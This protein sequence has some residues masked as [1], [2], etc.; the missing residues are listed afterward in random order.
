MGFRFLALPTIETKMLVFSDLL[1]M[2]KADTANG[3]GI[4]WYKKT[5]P[6]LV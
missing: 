4:F 6:A 2:P 1:V 5:T 3:L